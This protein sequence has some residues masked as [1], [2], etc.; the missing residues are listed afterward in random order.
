MSTQILVL[1]EIDKLFT[2]DSLKE[3]FKIYKSIKLTVDCRMF[4]SANSNLSIADDYLFAL[5]LGESIY[6]YCSSISYCENSQSIDFDFYVEEIC[7]LASILM[8][9]AYQCNGENESDEER[10]NYYMD[11]QMQF[12][13]KLFDSNIPTSKI[14]FPQLA[15]NYVANTIAGKSD[16]CYD[17]DIIQSIYKS[18]PE[19]EFEFWRSFFSYY[20]GYPLY[21]SSWAW[22]IPYNANK[23]EEPHNLEELLLSYGGFG[24]ELPFMEEADSFVFKN[25]P[26]IVLSNSAMMLFPKI[27]FNIAQKCAYS[28]LRKSDH[29]LPSIDSTAYSNLNL[30]IN[31]FRDV[32]V[33]QTLLAEDGSFMIIRDDLAQYIFFIDHKYS[34]ES[35]LTLQ[36]LDSSVEQDYQHTFDVIADRMSSLAGYDIDISCPWEKL[37]DESFEQLCYDLIEWDSYFDHETRQKMGKSRSRDGGRDIEVCTGSKLNKPVD[38]W[39]VQCKLLKKSTSLAGSKVQVSDVIDQY[40]A[41]GF[42]IMTN[43]VIDATLHDKLDGISKNRSIDIKKWGCLEIERILA[44]PKYKNIRKRYFGI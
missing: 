19:E 27:G 18:S 42:W 16:Y 25:L 5:F 11:L 21:T 8:M 33:H 4:R 34:S 23:G 39:I 14:F 32:K 7:D 26:T 44:K 20:I 35:S 36:H 1:K 10:D 28:I 38:K 24:K 37:D 3:Y 12:Q 15:D 31:H 30:K 6:P 17:E 43:G 41:K 29:S 40:G 2:V 9:F 22:L 13:E